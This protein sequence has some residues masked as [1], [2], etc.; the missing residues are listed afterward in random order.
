MSG[1]RPIGIGETWRHA[2]A[3]AL[4]LATGNEVTMN[5]K[6]DNLCGGLD[7]GIDGAIHA[8]RA[9]W[10]AHHT[11]EDWVFLLIDARNAFNELDRMM[12]LWNVQHGWP[13]GDHFMF[14]SYKHWA[15]LVIRKNDGTGDF[16]F[17]RQ[18]ITQEDPFAMFGYTL[19][20]LS[21]AL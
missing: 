21:L 10:G 1:V 5:C 13:S 17:S 14:N 19:G 12:M 18:G 11:E 8:A 6:T 20:L 15:S 7:G 3:K 16:L 2:I 9:M 4:L